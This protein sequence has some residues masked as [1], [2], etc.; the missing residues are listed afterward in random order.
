VSRFDLRTIESR[1]FASDPCTWATRLSDDRRRK[2]RTADRIS[3]ITL[4]VE[5]VA[6]AKELDSA[7]FGLPVDFLHFSHLG[8]KC[9]GFARLSPA[10]LT[11]VETCLRL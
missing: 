11:Q 9:F 8:C 7:V 2:R 1:A 3:A 4:F 5:D 10:T 6:A